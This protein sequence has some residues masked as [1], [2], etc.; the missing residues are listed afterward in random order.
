[1]LDNP[2]ASCRSSATFIISCDVHDLLA[3]W[4]LIIGL[5]ILQIDII[6]TPYKA[7]TICL[8]VYANMI[9][10]T[11]CIMASPLSNNSSSPMMLSPTAIWPS[12][13]NSDVSIEHETT[14]LA[15]A[16]LTGDV[17]QVEVLINLGVIIS[18]RHHWT[19]YHACLQSVDM[20]AALLA[21]PELSFNIRIPNN[22]GE[23]IIQL[24]S[25]HSSISLRL[26][27]SALPLVFPPSTFVQAWGRASR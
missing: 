10:S 2:W 9:H 23:S 7:I 11:V 15:M 17:G 16:I 20:I 3:N 18:E 6:V 22:E 21:S 25:A 27:P 1:M 24:F 14:V 5:I 13:P 26:L 8:K 12:F 4:D 19:L